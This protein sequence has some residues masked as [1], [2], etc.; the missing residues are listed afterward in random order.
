MVVPATL[1]LVAFGEFTMKKTL[2]AVLAC[3]GFVAASARSAEAQTYTLTTSLSYP[4]LQLN[5]YSYSPYPYISVSRV[6]SVLRLS[7]GVVRATVVT[8]GGWSATIDFSP[9]A[10]S[11][12]AAPISADAAQVMG[13]VL[14]AYQADPSRLM[15]LK[16]AGLNQWFL[17]SPSYTATSL[18]TITV[19]TLS[20]ARPPFYPT[21]GLRGGTFISLLVSDTGDTWGQLKLNEPKFDDMHPNGNDKTFCALRYNM[22]LNP[23]S[24]SEVGRLFAAAMT[25][26]GLWLDD[27]WLV[28]VNSCKTILGNARWMTFE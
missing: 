16:I 28:T 17:W 27:R 6:T 20:I 3:V 1:Q 4:D 13:D 8:T 5:Y 10:W 19:D 14:A 12:W 15:P 23:M 26:N 22:S 21:T 7:G 25:H 2:I 11:F 24:A 9:T 18:T